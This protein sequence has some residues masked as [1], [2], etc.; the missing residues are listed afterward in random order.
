[1]MKVAV[2]GMVGNSAFM[3]VERFHVGE[4]T[5]RAESIHYEMG[6][7]GFNQAIAAARCGASVSFLSAIGNEYERD[8]VEWL[9]RDGLSHT[10]VKKDGATAFAAILTDAEGRNHVTVY[11]GV[12]LSREDVLLFEDSIAEADVLL[13]NNEVDESVNLKALE[14]AKKNGVFVILNPAPARAY[15]KEIIEGVDLFTPNEHELEGIEELDNLVVTLGGRGCLLKQSG[16][17]VPAVNSGT[18]VDTTGA[19]DTFNGTLAAMISAGHDLASAAAIANRAASLSV[20]RR[21]AAGSIPTADE[22]KKIINEC[23]DNA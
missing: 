20:T 2:I 12:R 23:S 10:L 16:V 19:G 1:M 6:G 21:Y 9:E 22:M 11:Q 15:S 5:V 4:E 8:T 7:K 17:T 14:C 3:P 18:V 13:L